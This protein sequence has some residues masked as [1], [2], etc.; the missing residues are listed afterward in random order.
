MSSEN[1]HQYN[2]NVKQIYQV[3]SV[4]TSNQWKY[5]KLIQQQLSIVEVYGLC[6]GLK[7]G[8]D[9]I[10]FFYNYKH[11]MNYAVKELIDRFYINVFSFEQWHAL[12]KRSLKHPYTEHHQPFSKASDTT[13][14][15][16]YTNSTYTYK[17]GKPKNKHSYSEEESFEKMSEEAS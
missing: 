10:G 9:F 13:S 3:L 8:R 17:S 11:S 4:T 6:P 1:L 15:A 5:C 16:S 7:K 12:R 2:A 14:K